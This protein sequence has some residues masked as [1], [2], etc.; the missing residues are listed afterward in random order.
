M[1][2]RLAVKDERN[3]MLARLGLC[4]SAGLGMDVSASLA[5][6]VRSFYSQRWLM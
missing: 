3:I 1:Q 6:N 5:A 2:G 4:D